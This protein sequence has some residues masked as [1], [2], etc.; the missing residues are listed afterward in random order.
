MK[1]LSSK[2]GLFTPARTGAGIL[3]R[4]GIVVLLLSV[5]AGTR[6]QAP[7]ITIEDVQRVTDR[8]DEAAEG[9]FARSREIRLRFHYQDRFL[10]DGDREQMAQWARPAGETL[11]Q[12]AATLH[13]YCRRIEAYE[14]DDWDRRFGVTGLWRRAHA[15]AERFTWLICRVDYWWAL[16]R[17]NPTRDERLADVIARCTSYADGE[18]DPT[19]CLLRAQ[20]LSRL[21]DHPTARDQA[22]RLLAETLEAYRSERRPPDATYFHAAITRLGLLDRVD[23]TLI[24]EVLTA[25]QR[26]ALADD[27]DILLRLA[28]LEL[29]CVRPR[30]DHVLQEVLRRSPEAGSFVGRVVL[31]DWLD[32]FSRN[33]LT[34]SYI[35]DRTPLERRLALQQAGHGESSEALPLLEFLEG[36]LEP[37]SGLLLFAKAQAQRDADP[38]AAMTSYRRAAQVQRDRS[39]PD[40]PVTPAEVAAL[41][42][43]LAWQLYLEDAEHAATAAEMLA[44]YHNL[45]GT[46]ANDEL[47]YAYALALHATGQRTRAEALLRQIRARG[48]PYALAAGLELVVRQI[49]TDDCDAACRRSARDELERL[50]RRPPGPEEPQ[51][52][53]RTQ[54]V[55]LYCRLL[56][57]TPDRW[58]A[59]TVLDLL[60]RTDGLEPADAAVLRCSALRTLERHPQAAK[61]LIGVLDSPAPAVADEITTLLAEA[62]ARIETWREQPSFADFLVDL[63]RLAEHAASHTQE[64]ETRDLLR[65]T[66]AECLALRGDAASINQAAAIVEALARPAWTRRVEWVRAQA[67]LLTARRQW[68]RAAECWQQI[69]AALRDGPDAWAWWQARYWQTWCHAQRE[70]VGD[71]TVRHAVE[72]LLSSRP[73]CP[74]FWKTHLAALASQP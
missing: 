47:E 55:L 62:S 8:A 27:P 69:A 40:L 58:A 67:R 9:F 11:V 31:D 5:V 20:C 56:L 53:A 21:A 72:V 2:D 6:A 39:D 33:E 65:L 18:Q 24:R 28:F 42:A 13:D 1:H 16:T 4:L 36:V 52:Q 66:E 15:A 22:S 41:G 26:T 35:L 51:Q 74:A 59:Q 37:P 45:A 19:V 43:K 64:A 71:D 48:G 25:L 49:Q 46:E 12:A 44:F 57:E 3:H 50:L 70:G 29:R 17:E 73:D 10:T 34:G 7:Q 61:A 60:S 14:G 38:V 68:T 30:S 23:S 54:A 63:C 32:R